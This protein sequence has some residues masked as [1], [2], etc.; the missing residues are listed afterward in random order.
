[1][2]LARKNAREKGRA[3][4]PLVLQDGSMAVGWIALI[5]PTNLGSRVREQRIDRA[6][7]WINLQVSHQLGFSKCL[8]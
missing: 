4:A 7:P 6:S 8:F 2:V 5:A 3:K 1:M